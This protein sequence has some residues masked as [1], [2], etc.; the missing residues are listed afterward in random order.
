MNPVRIIDALREI[1][2]ELATIQ[3]ER[4]ELMVQKEELT[5]RFQQECISLRQD[6]SEA[7]QMITR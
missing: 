7:S 5:K 4:K 6:I 2:Q 1:Q 3:Q